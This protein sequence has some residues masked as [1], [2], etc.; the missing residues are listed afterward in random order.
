MLRKI[1]ILFRI[2][3]RLAKSDALEIISKIHKPPLIIKTLLK[4]HKCYLNEVKEFIKLFGYEK[5]NSM[6]HITGGGFVS[7][8]KRVIPSNMEVKLNDF[9]LPDWCDY[10]LQ[11]GINKE[12]LMEVFN[13]GIGFVLIVNKNI[14]MNEFP[15][16]YQIIG[17]I[18]EQ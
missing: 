11:C 13:C 4:P 9:E 15:Y 5:L 3:R 17:E 8:M 2:A 18:I 6:C 7:N 10:I 16:D 1:F 12:E 14:N